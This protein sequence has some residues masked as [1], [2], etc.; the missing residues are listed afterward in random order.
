VGNLAEEV[1]NLAEEV[2]NLADVGNLGG[3]AR[4]W[5]MTAHRVDLNDVSDSNDE[6]ADAMPVASAVR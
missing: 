4:R 5:V 3:R 1:V 2:V 6:G